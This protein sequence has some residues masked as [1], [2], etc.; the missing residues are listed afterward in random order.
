MWG[1]L[2]EDKDEDKDDNGS[3][4][5]LEGGLDKDHSEV[6]FIPLINKKLRMM[7]KSEAVDESADMMTLG[8]FPF[9]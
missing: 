8:S 5:S 7:K 4:G 1:P 2:D 9:K 6:K 3:I